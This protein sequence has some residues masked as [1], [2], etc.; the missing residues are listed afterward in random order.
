VFVPAFSAATTGV[1]PGDAGVASAV[2]NTAQQVG[3]SLGTALLNSLATAAT[4]T[5]LATHPHLPGP[6]ALVHGYNVAAAWAAGILAFAALMVAVIINAPR[7]Q[8]RRAQ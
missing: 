4:V 6:A 2:A 3:A 1:G 7:P 8:Q 5:Y